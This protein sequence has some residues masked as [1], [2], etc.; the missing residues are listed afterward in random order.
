ETL[1]I[2]GLVGRRLYRKQRNVDEVIQ[3]GI[4]EGVQ[5]DRPVERDRCSCVGHDGQ[6]VADARRSGRSRDRLGRR[7]RRFDRR[8]RGS[9]R[10]SSRWR[11]RRRGGWW[12]GSPFD[13]RQIGLRKHALIRQDRG[14]YGGPFG[15]RGRFY[16]GEV[17][18]GDRALF[19]QYL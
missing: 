11:W 15:T 5:Q 14:Q 17:G 13:A 6:S 12:R 7:G 18:G 8:G 3:G 10:R 2:P 16:A 1:V 9:L 19:D 4:R